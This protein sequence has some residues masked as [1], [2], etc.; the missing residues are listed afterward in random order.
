VLPSLR[1][2]RPTVQ[3][4]VAGSSCPASLRDLCQQARVKLIENPGSLNTV[5]SGASAIIVPLRIGSGSR[6]KIIEAGAHAL[7]VI[8]T[9]TGAD[10][11][12]LDPDRHLIQSD[13][14]AP[15]FAKACLFGLSHPD[16]ARQRATELHGHVARNHNRKTTVEDIAMQLAELLTC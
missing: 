10:G 11:L 16:E 13:D 8:S 6:L 4:V 2:T 14:D 12:D 15:S 1:A 7:P 3:I 9:R 5:Y